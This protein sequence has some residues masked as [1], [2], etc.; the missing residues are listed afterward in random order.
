MLVQLC[1]YFAFSNAAGCNAYMADAQGPAYTQVLAYADGYG[2]GY[3]Y[4]YLCQNLYAMCE[5][6]CAE[7]TASLR[8][9]ARDP[10]CKLSS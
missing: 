5:R 4:Q 1:N 10:R 3:D 9:C 6:S 7:S 2:D 8:A